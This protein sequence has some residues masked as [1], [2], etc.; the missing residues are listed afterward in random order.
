[1]DMHLVDDSD[2]M[3][4]KGG[5]ILGRKDWLLL[6]L[7]AAKKQGLT[8]VQLQ[9]SLFLI[10]KNFQNEV[11]HEFYCFDPYHYG[12]FDSAIYR[13]AELLAEEGLIEILTATGR[14][15]PKYYLS[16][17][18]QQHALNLH[19]SVPQ[20][21]QTY[22]GDLIAWVQSISFQQLL[23]IIYKEYPEFKA[24]SVFRG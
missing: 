8:P 7:E 18:G 21:L 13:D 6:V 3:G 16:S 12:P 11:G 24:N 17:D 22:I 15:Y 1:M 2:T 10:G 5:T 4:A 23:R 19:Q 20:R 14:K 9:K